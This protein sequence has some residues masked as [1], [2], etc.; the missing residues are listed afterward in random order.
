[1]SCLLTLSIQIPPLL[2]QEKKTVDT[3]AISVRLAGMLLLHNAQI[4]LDEIEALPLVN[5]TKRRKRWH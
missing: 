1:M 2:L 3:F 5:A 4:A